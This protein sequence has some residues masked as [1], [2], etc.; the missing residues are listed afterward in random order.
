M[1][2]HPNLTAFLIGFTPAAVVMAL[3]LLMD[4]LL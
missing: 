1:S 3:V 4:A 2:R